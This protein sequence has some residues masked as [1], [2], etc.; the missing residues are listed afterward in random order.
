MSF[1]S[2][3]YFFCVSE[4]TIFNIF[5]TDELVLPLHTTRDFVCVSRN[6]ILWVV[7]TSIFTDNTQFPD[8]SAI[9][10]RELSNGSTQA[11]LTFRANHE[12]NNTNIRCGITS[13]PD[14][15]LYTLLNYTITIQGNTLNL[16]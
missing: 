1:N 14:F 9:V 5:C 4:C 11:N 3:E 6:T 16:I 13:Y 7:N 12:R 8:G 2:N 10:Y 15:T